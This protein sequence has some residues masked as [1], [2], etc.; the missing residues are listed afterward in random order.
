MKNINPQRLKEAR[1]ANDYTQEK[2][3]SNIGKTKGLIS[4]WESGKLHPDN[5]TLLQISDLLDVNIDWFYRDS[6]I[7]KS[8]YQ[9]RSNKQTSSNLKDFVSTRLKWLSEIANILEEW[10][11]FPTLNLPPALNRLQSLNLTNDEIESY[12]NQLREYWQLDDK[13]ISN[14][15]NIAEANGVIS[16]K[17][18]IG[19]EKMDGVSAWFEQRPVIWLAQDKFNYYR[20]RFD[21]AH[22]IGHIVLHK[23]LTQEDYKARYDEIERQAHLFASHFLIPRKAL[24]LNHRSIT[25]DNLLI[26]K[27]HW[28]VSVSALIMQYHNLNV[29]N[30]DY[31][32]RLFKNYSY[33]KWRK[34]EPFDNQTTPERPTLLRTAIELLINQGGFSNQDIIDKLGCGQAH[35]ESLCCLSR[36]FLNTNQSTK[37]YLRFV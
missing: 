18:P 24:L 5:Q 11:E 31:K 25:L 15:T 14:L 12:A 21:I 33:R 22:E 6:I 4:K 37:T 35:I 16:T 27:R 23:N 26:L 9:Y 20:S 34:N 32:A 2:L 30:D 10:V 28:G 7:E 19:S 1:L 17:E 13:P 36:E 3:A 8:V 29:I